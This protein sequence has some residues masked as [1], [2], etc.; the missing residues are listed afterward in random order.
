MRV[1]LLLLLLVVVSISSRR[2][3]VVVDLLEPHFG[4]SL[5]GKI[6]SQVIPRLYGPPPPAAVI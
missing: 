5:V 6:S 3:C 1:F 4:L 2:P